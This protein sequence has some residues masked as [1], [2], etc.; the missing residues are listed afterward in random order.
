VP[1]IADLVQT[2]LARG[3]ASS[4]ELQRELNVSQPT[5]SRVMAQLGDQV[6][7]IGGGRSTRYGLRRELA[8][9]GSSWPVFQVNELGQP[10]LQGRLE[11]LARD[12]YWFAA[13]ADQY[14]QVTGGL[15]YFLQDLWPQGF[16][17]RTVP[18]RFPELGLPPRITDWKDGHALTYLT[19][20]GEDP[21][22]QLFIGDESL[23][24]YLNQ[25]QTRQT[26][27]DREDRANQ[28]SALAD[29]AIA[30]TPPGSAAGG[31]HPK[32]TTAVRTNDE[33]RQVLVKFSPSRTDRV[34][35]RWSDLLIAEHIASKALNI[36]G[37]RATATELMV[38]GNRMFLESERF[39]RMGQRG[40]I[41]V[42]SLAALADHYIGRRDNWIA[43]CMSLKSTGKIQAQDFET[44]RRAATFGQLIGNTDMH[45]GNLS[46]FFAFGRR[47]TLAPIYDMLPMIYAPL[48]GNETLVDDF[49]PPLPAASNLDIWRSIAEL[50]EAYW[51]AVAAHELVSREFSVQA[52]SNVERIAKLKTSVP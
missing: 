11:A 23:Q 13:T 39:D 17:G 44:V 7:R 5:L 14:S 1:D 8:Q 25:L 4:A 45:F 12:Q 6:V 35:Q 34:S 21:V 29:L 36:L 33:W 51:R 22:G 9:I 28:Y 46:F 19:R 47:L 42:V 52:S 49:E 48:A 3:L 50:A 10:A 26:Q 32:F 40:R 2:S 37:V 41:G 15:P 24:R 30:G 18:K 31:Q 27:V 38:A 20:R 16:I 43:A